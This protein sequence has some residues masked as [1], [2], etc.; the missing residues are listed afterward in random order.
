MHT[1]LCKTLDDIRKNA[2]PYEELRNNKNKQWRESWV[3]AK[4]CESLN[5]A[6]ALVCVPAEDKGD[7]VFVKHDKKS[8]PF[9]ITEMAPRDPLVTKN[10]PSSKEDE[11]GL[12]SC[13]VYGSLA[14]Q[15]TDLVN[16]LVQKKNQK[17]YANQENMNL[18][19]YLNLPGALFIDA[20]EDIDM[21][22]LTEQ[23]QSSKFK[24]ISLYE[25]GK[26]I[27]IKGDISSLAQ[28]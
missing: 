2:P 15:I 10:L 12:I 1:N 19:I 25:N 9:Q 26:V 28:V 20:E 18:L 3:T 4:F 6:D 7:D 23:M 5:W 11:N 24:T 21:A 17:G 8:Y 16:S 27:F 13:E 14:P 22:A